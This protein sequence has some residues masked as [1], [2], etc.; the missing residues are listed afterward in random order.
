VNPAPAEGGDQPEEVSISAMRMASA[1][2][3]SGV[4]SP[5][6][7][8]APPATAA[9]MVSADQRRVTTIGP[10]RTPNALRR[11]RWASIGS[12]TLL[13]SGR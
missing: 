5:S 2:T 3:T 1:S 6:L 4:R 11:R 13:R 7:V 10:I 8:A 12:I 9:L